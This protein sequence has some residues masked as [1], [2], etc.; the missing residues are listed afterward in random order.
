MIGDDV[1]RHRLK[2]H[3]GKVQ[4]VAFSGNDKYLSTLGGQDDNALVIWDVA[5]GSSICGSPAFSDSAICCTWLHG[6]SDRLVTAGNNHIRVWQ[7]DFS[8]PKLHAMDAKLG[9]VRR[10]VSSITIT[11]DDKIAYCGTTT[12]DIIKVSIERNEILSFK[13]PDVKVPQLIGISTHRFS[14]AVKA[15]TCVRNPATGNYNLLVGAGDGALSFMN[16]SLSLVSGYKTQLMGG[17]TSIAKH[18]K[19][20][21]Y[22][23]G[24]AECNTYQVSADLIQA[25]LMSSCHTGSITDIAFPEGCPD[26]VV[27]SS[28]G[29]MR[30]W[31]TRLRQELLRIQVPNVECLSSVVTPSGSSILSGWDDGKIR[32]FYPET[33]RMKF[34]IPDA[35]TEKVTAVAVA[36]NDARAPWRI[37]SGG[38]EGRVRIWKVPIR[39]YLI[40]F[41]LSSSNHLMLTLLISGDQLPP[42]DVILP[43]GAPRAH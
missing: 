39:N 11:D 32:A 13:D 2:Q 33:G 4:D 24:T 9:S 43:E 27:T 26:L 31:N 35:H 34:V 18:P 6:R 36:D 37:I 5:S 30:I 23:V 21:K 7:V 25:D 10:V 19:G 28:R 1:C 15:L 40:Y 3:L 12:G 42:G 14:L 22:I 16:P 41:P 29:D 8:L 38:A 20:D 17:I